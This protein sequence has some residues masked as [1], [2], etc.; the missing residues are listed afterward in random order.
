MADVGVFGVVLVGAFLLLL[1]PAA[2]AELYSDPAAR[3][4]LASHGVRFRTV[5]LAVL[6]ATAALFALVLVGTVPADLPR[7]VALPVVGLYGGTVGSVLGVGRA[8]TLYRLT[9][10]ERVSTGR[11][12]GTVAVTGP[13]EAPDPPT[14]PFF[15]RPAV[16]WR[17]TVWAKNRHGIVAH[18]GDGWTRARAG[19][20]GV[21]FVLDDGSG[22]LRVDPDGAR[23]DLGAERRVERPPDDPP[24]RAAEVV[25]LDVGGDR[26]R[27]VESVLSPGER[28]TVLG[29]VRDG[30]TRPDSSSPSLVAR[31]D[32]RATSRRVAVR[33]VGLG[34]GG[35]AVGLGSFVLLAE[36]LGVTP[37]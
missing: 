10:A 16:A 25:E 6:V 15:E 7:A 23:L 26:F 36:L 22:P 24:G 34:L 18:G 21:A 13:V 8:R 4:M 12:S 2:L 32:A 19:S 33:A 35:L 27:F 37:V 30:R 20:G 3:A 14:S 28:A 31:G 29:T 9:A 1:V 11:A 17:W 5:G